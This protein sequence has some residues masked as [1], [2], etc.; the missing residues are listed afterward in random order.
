[1]DNISDMSAE[2]Q[3]FIWTAQ[4]IATLQYW[5]HAENRDRTASIDA[6][7]DAMLALVPH[8]RA[9]PRIT[10]HTILA[11]C[12]K[13][14]DALSQAGKLAQPAIGSDEMKAIAS[15][16]INFPEV[17]AAISWIHAGGVLSLPGGSQPLLDEIRIHDCP[18]RLR[19]LVAARDQR[20]T[21]DNDVLEV[22]ASAG[23]ETA[24]A[25]IE[26]AKTGDLEFSEI[27]CETSFDEMTLKEFAWLLATGT[28][29][30]Q[31]FLRF[32]MD[33]VAPAEAM[34]LIDMLASNHGRLQLTTLEPSL[35]AICVGE[36]WDVFFGLSSPDTYLL[37]DAKAIEKT[38]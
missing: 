37:K 18:R 24:K 17:E 32:E 7:T 25:M 10:A 20:P 26:L 9:D 5:K 23:P 15:H 14:I 16:V 3:V 8:L 31:Y 27:L 13:V 12:P 22:F 21:Y 33:A 1:M 38:S 35:E 6:L 2:A 4:S 19:L 28:D 11:N 36:P 29:L 34:D 30:E